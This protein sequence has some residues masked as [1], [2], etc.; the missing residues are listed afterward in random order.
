MFFYGRSGGGPAL[1][2][3]FQPKVKRV[4]SEGFGLYVS[5]QGFN[6]KKLGRPQSGVLKNGRFARKALFYPGPGVI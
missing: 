4:Q 5:D 2:Y 1:G 3:G 6:K